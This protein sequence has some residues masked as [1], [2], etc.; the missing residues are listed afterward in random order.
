[1]NKNELYKVHSAI[2]VI[3]TDKNAILNQ[4]RSRYTHKHYVSE[5]M[6]YLSSSISK[7]GERKF[8]TLAQ[9]KFSK[10]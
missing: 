6:V 3:P 8:G 7:L 2:I 9:Q 1:M 10:R 5:K 4:N